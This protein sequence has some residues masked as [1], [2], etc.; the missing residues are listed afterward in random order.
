ML[1]I[2]MVRVVPGINERKLTHR[3][4]ADV[5]GGLAFT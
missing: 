4:I 3:L 5:Q 1:M 2:R